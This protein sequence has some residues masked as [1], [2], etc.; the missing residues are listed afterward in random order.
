MVLPY[1][2]LKRRDRDKIVSNR[3]V[4]RER[5]TVGKHTLSL[6]VIEIKGNQRS[7]WLL[8]HLDG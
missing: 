6:K 2:S 4:E 5:G 8:G 3:A 1:A 7:Q